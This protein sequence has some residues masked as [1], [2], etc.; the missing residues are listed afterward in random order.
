MLIRWLTICVMVPSLL[1]GNC[2]KSVAD[3]SAS[4]EKAGPLVAP[5]PVDEP[6]LAEPL[7][8]KI[9]R[10]PVLVES[11]I[12]LKVARYARRYV[13]VRDKNGDGILQTEEWKSQHDE[14]AH[15]DADDNGELIWIEIASRITRYG[16]ARALRPWIVGDSSSTVTSQNRSVRMVGSD[17]ESNQPI[18]R[19]T[20]FYVPSS[21][22]S[23]NLPKWFVDRDRDGDG[24]LTLREFAPNDGV[25]VVRQF[26]EYDR[27]RDGVVVPRELLQKPETKKKEEPTNKTD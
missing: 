8:V 6:E 5:L 11:Q 7:P 19:Q 26:R 20:R 12:P 9:D 4:S 10:L 15:V 17:E 3:E 25:G 14:L 2:A 13:Q 23:S 21:R 1:V 27:N 22:L 16:Q 24:Q 18:Q